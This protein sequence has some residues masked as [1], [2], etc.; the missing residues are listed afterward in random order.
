MV[1]G[2]ADGLGIV[3]VGDK[4][5][6]EARKLSIESGDAGYLEKPFAQADIIGIV[7]PLIARASSEGRLARQP[8]RKRLPDGISPAPGALL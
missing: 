6:P 3:A 5:D 1:E 8:R 2:K 4:T 7:Q